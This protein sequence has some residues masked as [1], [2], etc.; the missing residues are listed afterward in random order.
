M[1]EDQ[2]QSVGVSETQVLNEET[3]VRK[4]KFIRNYAL[5]IY[6]SDRENFNFWS[7]KSQKKFHQWVN[8]FEVGVSK[9]SC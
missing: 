4:L 5:I 7:E 9:S 3:E 8:M 2:S 6:E 1:A